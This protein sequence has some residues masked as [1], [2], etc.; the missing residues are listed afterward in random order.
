[1]WEKRIDVCMMRWISRI[2]RLFY[3]Q[4]LNHSQLTQATE[5]GNA[6]K[7][8]PLQVFQEQDHEAHVRAHIILIALSSHTV[9]GKSARIHNV[10]S[11]CTRTCW[12][13]GKRSGNTF[14]QKSMQEAQMQG[15]QSPHDP[16]AVEAHPLNKVGEILK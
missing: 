2:L 3:H 6:M 12:Y 15:Q 16:S 7:N 14:F 13:D 11:S 4:N 1:M 8:M 9:T 10:A 5:N